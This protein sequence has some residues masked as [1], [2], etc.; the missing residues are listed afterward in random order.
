MKRN[1]GCRDGLGS[2]VGAGRV[3]FVSRSIERG[4]EDLTGLHHSDINHC[5]RLLYAVQVGLLNDHPSRALLTASRDYR[6][7]SIIRMHWTID[8][9]RS[10]AST[11][12]SG[13][14][15]F[16]KSLPGLSHA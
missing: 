6:E 1:W 11:S 10:L 14:T 2:L 8:Y 9:S 4:I 5:F 16:T 15:S 13:L 12:W 3:L 7:R